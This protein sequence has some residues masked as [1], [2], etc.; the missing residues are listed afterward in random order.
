MSAKF[1]SWAMEQKINRWELWWE[2]PS[3]EV[4]LVEDLKERCVSAL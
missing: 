4:L 2:A 3:A 1:R